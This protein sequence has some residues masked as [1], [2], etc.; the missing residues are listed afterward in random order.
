MLGRLMLASLAARRARLGLALVAVTL[1][2]AVAIALAT[3]ALQVGDDLARTLRAAGPNF[4]VLPAGASTALDLGGAPIEPARAG[5]ALPESTTALLKSSFWKNNVLAAAPE[6][7]LTGSINGAPARI[8]GTWFDREIA[9]ADG[10][11]RT[12]LGRLRAGW[13]V[14]GRWPREG[15]AELALGRE[16]ATTLGVAPGARVRATLGGR[17][18]AWVVAGVV[19]AGGLE[20]RMAW[21]PLERVQALTARAGVDRIW[22]SALVR[23]PSKKPAPDPKRDPKGYERYM[24]TSYPVVVA[25]VVAENLAGAEVLPMT[26]VVTGEGE[27][28]GRLNLLM[29]LLALAALTASTLGLL[30]TT[31]ATVVERAVE[32]GLMRALGA[33][34]GQIAVL[35]LGET[36][37]VSLAGGALGFWLGA[38]AAVAIRGHT[39]GTASPVQPLLLPLALV[40][41]LALAFLGTLAPLRLA[42]RVDPA[43]VLRG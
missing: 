6:L 38:I 43:T 18:D 9:T 16:L 41:S 33:S 36:V 12:G 25:R 35:L 28:V 32:L 15:A 14:E 4:V 19:T 13:Q 22:M 20:D 5:L 24:C 27:V 29:L 37:L 23:A 2:V 11:W 26:E 42:L 21:A 8:S 40:L 1:G 3:L 17:E 7:S 39:F 34:A 10:P 31:T 30:S